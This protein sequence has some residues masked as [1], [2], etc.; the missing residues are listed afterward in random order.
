MIAPSIPEM[1]KYATL[2]MAT[3]ALYGFNAKTRPNQAPG[4]LLSNTGH[5]NDPLTA[6]ILTTGNEHAS[7][8]APAEAEKFVKDWIVIDHLSNT[9]T[10]FSGTLFYNEAENQYVLSIRSTEFI[11]DTLRDSVATNGMEIKEFGWV[12]GQISDMEAWYA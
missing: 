2:Q 1:L 9:T 8:F 5:F 12:F 6:D 3:E 11:D 7:R 10:G 4:D